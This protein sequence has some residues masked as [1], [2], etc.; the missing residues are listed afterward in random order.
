MR[1]ESSPRFDGTT[2]RFCPTKEPRYDILHPAANKQPH[3]F[4]LFQ[5]GLH[6][7]LSM[8]QYEIFFMSQL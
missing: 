1:M 2:S 8:L 5:P 7:T 6:C 4:V 3:F